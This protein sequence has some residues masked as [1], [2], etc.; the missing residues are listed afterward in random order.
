MG[1]DDEWTPR[2][3][4]QGGSHSWNWKRAQRVELDS[5]RIVGRWV[6]CRDCGTRKLQSIDRRTGVIV[7]NAYVY[8]NE[9]LRRGRDGPTKAEIRAEH[10]EALP[11]ADPLDI[12]KYLRR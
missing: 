4:C 11:E 8:P 2:Y 9:Y 10:V 5:P 6:R 12:R 1:A 3:V 7:D